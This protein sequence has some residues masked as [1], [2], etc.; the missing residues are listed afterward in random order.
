MNEKERE[1][2]RESESKEEIERTSVNNFFVGSG[3]RCFTSGPARVQV[4]KVFERPV[5]D[6]RQSTS[7]LYGGFAFYALHFFLFGSFFSL[8]LIFSFHFLSLSWL[9]V[10]PQCKKVQNSMRTKRL[11][12]SVTNLVEE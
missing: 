3:K 12:M 2:G 4:S 5:C 7:M 10:T 1:R 9:I 8:S 6:T 11:K